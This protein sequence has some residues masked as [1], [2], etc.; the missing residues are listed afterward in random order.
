MHTE[1]DSGSRHGLRD[2]DDESPN[3]GR[4]LPIAGHDLRHHGDAEV[5]AQIKASE[6][7]GSSGWMLWNAAVVYHE[8]ALRA[9]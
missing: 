3:A 2:G 9:P 7:F 6:D 4:D 8:G 5:R 1:S